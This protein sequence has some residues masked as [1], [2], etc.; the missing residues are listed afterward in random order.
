VSTVRTPDINEDVYIDGSN[1]LSRITATATATAANK[2][3]VEFLTMDFSNYGTPVTIVDPAPN[4]VVSF[5]QFLQDAAAKNA[6][7]GA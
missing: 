1:R 4:D 5:S 7:T 2:S 6:A 3:V